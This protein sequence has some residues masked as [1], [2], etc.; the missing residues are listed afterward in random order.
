MDDYFKQVSSQGGEASGLQQGIACLCA[1]AMFGGVITYLV[2]LGIYAYNNPDPLDAWWGGDL[3][4]SY[5]TELAAQTA[6]G[7]GVEVQNVHL[8]YVTWFV[9]GFWTAISP[10]IA[11]PV[12]ITLGCFGVQALLQLIG[13]AFGC[14]YACSSLFWF[15]FGIVWRWGSMGKACT[16]GALKNE[17]N[18]DAIATIDG[19]SAGADGVEPTAEVEWGLQA[20]GGAFMNVIVWIGVVGLSIQ[21][22]F[23]TIAII[24][25]RSG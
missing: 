16:R 7:V 4:H 14:G 15:I 18:A 22:L 21:L 6:A 5:T 25:A 19:R 2:F 11:I 3:T 12:F 17:A 13:A 20:K 1:L 10:C 8:V 23:I 24:R 9:W